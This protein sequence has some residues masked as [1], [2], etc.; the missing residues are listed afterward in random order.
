MTQVADLPDDFPEFLRHS[1]EDTPVPTWK[2]VTRNGESIDPEFVAHVS[3]IVSGT[4]D[5]QAA[6]EV[7]NTWPG[8]CQRSIALLVD[9]IYHEGWLD[10]VG[11][12]KGWPWDGGIFFWPRPGADELADVLNA[13]S[14]SGG[15][16]TQCTYRA[17][18]SAWLARWGHEAWKWSWIEND[19]PVAS[20]HIGVF[21]DGSA[22]VHLDVFNPLYVN[23]PPRSD[24][25][26]LPLIGSYNHELFRLHR[27][28]ERSQY[29]SITRTSANFYHLMLG[30]VPLSF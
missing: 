5:E 27:R 26:R 8:N 11:A 18:L 1:D 20:L 30:R 24:V 14:G 15:A 3:R 13:K 6:M 19:S 4:E 22:E 23:G 10:S 29:A 25:T 28:W 9:K 12:I 7:W 16:Y 2:Q 21:E 17:G